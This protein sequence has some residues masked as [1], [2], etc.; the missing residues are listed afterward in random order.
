MKKFSLILLMAVLALPMMAQFAN[1]A[2]AMAGKVEK[3]TIEQGVVNPLKAFNWQLVPAN[4]LRDTETIVW[5]FEDDD[6]FEGW[7]SYDADGDGYGWE[8]ESYYAH[9]GDY[10]LTSRS[11]YSG[12]L[13][14]DNWLISPEVPL[15][16]SL[17]F[18]AMN[19]LSSWP[20]QIQV[21]VCIG[22]PTTIDEA[23][24]LLPAAGPSTTS[25]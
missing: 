11:Y 7:L 5:D 22:E 17:S 23:S 9:S 19:Y 16:G 25:T 10:S 1:K 13:D 6:D 2:D 3:A 12:A 4:I 21:Y 14:P 18:W 24:L 15:G 20:D 8:V